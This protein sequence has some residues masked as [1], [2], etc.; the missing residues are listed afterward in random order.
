MNPARPAPRRGRLP[1]TLRMPHP[2]AVRDAGAACPAKGRQWPQGGAGCTAAPARGRKRPPA[3]NTRKRRVG[4]MGDAPQSRAQLRGNEAKHGRCLQRCVGCWT[5]RNPQ[6]ECMREFRACDSM[7]SSPA[8]TGMQPAFQTGFAILGFR[9]P[10][11]LQDMTRR[12][13]RARIGTTR[14]APCASP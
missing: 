8:S 2:V 13:S 3:W 4:G 12:K 7:E 1:W 9:S 6:E 10:K 14:A 5:E 11:K